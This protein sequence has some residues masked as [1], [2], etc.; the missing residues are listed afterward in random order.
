MKLRGSLTF[1]ASP[2]YELPRDA[3]QNNIYEI[4]ITA[5]DGSLSASLDVV[6]TVTDINEAAT[7][8][9]PASR[10]YAEN[11]TALVAEYLAAG[12]EVD[13]SIVWTVGG[14]DASHFAISEEGGLSF[15]LPPDY[16][17]PGDANENNIY[18]IT[19]AATDGSQRVAR[20]CW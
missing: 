4:T 13:D 2:D 6:V 1:K 18:E 3:N 12:L 14:T 19:I 16:E 9:G 5:T 7:I 20:R 8:T 17:S 10:N 15:K 11:G